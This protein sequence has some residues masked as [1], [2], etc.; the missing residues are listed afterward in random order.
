MQHS[1]NISLEWY[2]YSEALNTYFKLF[3]HV[4]FYILLAVNIILL[5]TMRNKKRA[6]QGLLLFYLFIEVTF[7]LKNL[8]YDSRPCLENE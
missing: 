7:T 3:S 2:N 8:F 4:F 6:F 1:I 5:F